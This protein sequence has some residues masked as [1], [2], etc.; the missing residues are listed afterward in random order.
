MD[1]RLKIIKDKYEELTQELSKPEVLGDYNTL[2]KLMVRFYIH[3]EVRITKTRNLDI[4][5]I[6]MPRTL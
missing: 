1:E 5:F 3:I 4:I 2:K 6:M